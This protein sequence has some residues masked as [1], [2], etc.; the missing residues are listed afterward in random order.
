MKEVLM[1]HRTDCGY[2]L[3]AQQALREL[4]EAEPRYR[5]VPLR[6]VDEVKES[7][8]ADQFDYYAVPTFYVGGEKLFEAHIGMSYEAIREQVKRALE[9]ALED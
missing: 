7:A 5:Q 4:T 3:K 6:Q 1:F 2:C 9:A 8:Y